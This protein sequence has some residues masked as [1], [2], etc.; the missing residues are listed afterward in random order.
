[1]SDARLVEFLTVTSRTTFITTLTRN[2][3][4]D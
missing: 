3:H 1:V 2:R 4:T